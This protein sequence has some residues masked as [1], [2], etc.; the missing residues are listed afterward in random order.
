MSYRQKNAL[1]QTER[2]ARARLYFAWLIC[3]LLWLAGCAGSGGTVSNEPPVTPQEAVP[4]APTAI[5]DKTQA[6]TDNVQLSVAPEPGKPYTLQTLVTQALN[7]NPALAAS[8][9]EWYARKEKY[10][11]EVSLPDPQFTYTLF[12]QGGKTWSGVNLMQMIP[13]PRKLY[14]QGKLA[15]READVAFLAQTRTAREVAAAVQKSFYEL[16]YIEAAI[17]IT[18]NN[19]E[20]LRL[21]LLSAEAESGKGNTVMA[22]VLR[23]QSQTAQAQYDLVRLEELRQVEIGQ[24]NALL[25]RPPNAPLVVTAGLP[26]VVAMPPFDPLYAHA[27]QHRQEIAAAGIELTMAD[28]RESL[29]L[30]DYF[31]DLTVGFGWEKMPDK[32]EPDKWML[33]FGVNLPLWW[34]KRAARVRETRYSREAVAAMKK[35]LEN[36]LAASLKRAYYKLTN[37]ARLVEL[38]EKTLLP[39]AQKSMA[40]AET[41]YRGGKGSLMATLETQA[42]YLNFS[43][44]TARAQSDYAQALVELS[45]LSGGSLPLEFFR[46][47][48]GK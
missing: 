27:L 36:E 16:A 26:Q 9:Q 37:A 4:A 14:L 11:Q 28:T 3:L 44:A 31:P 38:Y 42:I 6:T 20:I 41:W 2:Q 30:N 32:E 10:A 1:Q 45:Q 25:N 35:N 13:F 39:Q 23:A 46:A 43:L 33:N 7:A 34:P 48:E 19:G 18:R 8:R 24:L 5:A 21:L 29:A 40:M 22:D 12:T 15:D 47:K 17:A